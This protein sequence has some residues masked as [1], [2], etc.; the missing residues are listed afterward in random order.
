MKANDR[1]ESIKSV[2]EIMN[3]LQIKHKV[4]LFIRSGKEVRD[5]GF[6]PLQSANAEKYYL[7]KFLPEMTKDDVEHILI[8]YLRRDIRAGGGIGKKMPEAK[9]VITKDIKKIVPHFWNKI[10]AVLD[11]IKTYVDWLYEYTDI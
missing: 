4:D 2:E 1:H 5:S 10:R 8:D 7:M 6:L 3:E 11:D 9:N